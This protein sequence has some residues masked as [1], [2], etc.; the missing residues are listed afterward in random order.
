MTQGIGGSGNH[1]GVKSEQ[2][3]TH[4]CDQSA[5]EQISVEF[6]HEQDQEQVRAKFAGF[7]VLSDGDR[8]E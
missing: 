5:A 2:E 7:R 4:R 6:H 3:T 1:S 8:L